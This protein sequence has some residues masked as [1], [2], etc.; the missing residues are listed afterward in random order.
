MNKSKKIEKNALDIFLEGV[1]N[2]EDMEE[3]P[4]EDTEHARLFDRDI[5]A[6]KKE[7]LNAIKGE[8]DVQET[9]LNL[10]ESFGIGPVME[11]WIRLKIDGSIP[12]DIQN[13]QGGA[14]KSILQSTNDWTRKDR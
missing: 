6:S 2:Y 1:E 8:S 9:I 13:A 14:W 10:V 12:K 3:S 7:I 5:T 11:A 4:I